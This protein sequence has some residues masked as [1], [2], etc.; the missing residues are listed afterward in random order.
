MLYIKFKVFCF[1]FANTKK[2][3][4]FAATKLVIKNIK[5][6]YIM[7]TIKSILSL[8]ILSSLILVS[9]G[10]KENTA[11]DTQNGTVINNAKIWFSNVPHCDKQAIWIDLNNN[12]NFQDDNAIYIVANPKAS[13]SLDAE[14]TANVRLTTNETASCEDMTGEQGPRTYKVAYIL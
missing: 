12:G 2:S 13:W 4:I 8:T 9:C 5:S 6:L 1:N 10:E 11:P 7:K 3:C 14:Q